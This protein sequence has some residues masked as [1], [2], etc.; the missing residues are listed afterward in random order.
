MSNFSDRYD[1]LEDGL[2]ILNI[3]GPGKGKSTF[4]GSV[5][6]VIDPERV[7]LII[8]KPREK[9]GWLYRKYGLSA[10]AEVFF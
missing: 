1:G 7:L 4:L 6:E 10:K 3:G 5:C 9:S 2:S 8:T